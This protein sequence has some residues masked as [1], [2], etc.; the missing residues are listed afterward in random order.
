MNL[1]Q[2][3]LEKR[4][5]IESRR[6]SSQHR[7]LDQFHEMVAT[8]L[9]HGD[10][11]QV[12]SAFTRF[13]DALEAHFSVED[14]VYFPAVH[15]LRPQLESELTSLVA[16]HREMRRQLEKVQDLFDADRLAEGGAAL[17]AM[18][19]VLIEH[20]TREERL[21]DQIQSR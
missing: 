2:N 10:P 4:V 1:K 12:R 13:R 18:V 14:D 20:E 7:Q 8:A 16:D 11:A 17:D 9:E 19:S 5:Q 15:G 6:I 3:G 21:L